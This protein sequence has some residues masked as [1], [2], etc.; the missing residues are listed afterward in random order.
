M[1]GGQPPLVPI[2][3][4]LK[5]IRFLQEKVNK[6]TLQYDTAVT[7][8]ARDTADAR[9]EAQDLRGRQDRTR[10]LTRKLAAKLGKENHAEGG[11]R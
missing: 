7:G 10:D 3:A 9:T 1:G 4:E 6:R 5:M 11:G 8:E 2:S